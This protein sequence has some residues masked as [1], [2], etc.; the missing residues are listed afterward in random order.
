VAAADVQDRAAEA[1][2]AAYSASIGRGPTR[3]RAAMRDRALICFLH[4]EPNGRPSPRAEE[5]FESEASAAIVRLTG[6]AVGGIVV[7]HE[8]GT[9]LTALVALLGRRLVPGP[10]VGE[11]EERWP[12]TGWNGL[13]RR[14]AEAREASGRLRAI[15]Q[16]LRRRD[17]PPDDCDP[18]LGRSRRPRRRIAH[19][20]PMLGAGG[21]AG[22]IV[23][24]RR[25]NGRDHRRL[26]RQ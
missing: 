8:P 24:Q 4:A 25:G 16:G 23:R 22:L 18:P 21:L 20:L 12:Q 14:A 15:S 26:R 3:A 2:A 13:G 19:W 9:G 10:E 1:I 6:R 5:T 11:R 17:D 7:E